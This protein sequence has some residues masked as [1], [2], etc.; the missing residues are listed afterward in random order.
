MSYKTKA[1]IFGTIAIICELLAITISIVPIYFHIF[2]FSKF[3]AVIVL[4]LMA[5]HVE[6]KDAYKIYRMKEIDEELENNLTK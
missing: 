6:C 4:I 1:N 3:I 5:I 2:G